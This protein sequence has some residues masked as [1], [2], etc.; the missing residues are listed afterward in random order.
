MA[1]PPFG[2]NF[3]CVAACD[4]CRQP[5]GQTRDD[6]CVGRWSKSPRTHK[7][8]ILIGWKGSTIGHPAGTLRALQQPQSGLQEGTVVR[9]SCWPVLVD[10]AS[11]YSHDY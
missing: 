10:N 5:R 6:V 9:F 3:S 1:N 7:N 4:R 8:P 11:W 2:W